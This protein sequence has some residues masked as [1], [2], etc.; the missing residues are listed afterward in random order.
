M[1]SGNRAFCSSSPRFALTPDEEQIPLGRLV[2][3]GYFGLDGDVDGGQQFAEQSA[4]KPMP[5]DGGTTLA[6]GDILAQ[7]AEGW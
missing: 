2:E 5:E 3:Q 6:H 1:P 7:M 4:H